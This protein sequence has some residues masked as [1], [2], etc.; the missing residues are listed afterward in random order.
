MELATSI[1]EAEVGTPWRR[2]LLH[3]G[4]VSIDVTFSLASFW[5]A[6]LRCST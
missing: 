1:M 4:S 2:N 5:N 6:A 3:L